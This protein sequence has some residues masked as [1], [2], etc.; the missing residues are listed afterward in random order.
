VDRKREGRI[1][2]RVDSDLEA[3]LRAAAEA[4]GDTLTGI[5]LAAG[6][7]RAEEVLERAGR[8]AVSASA[9]ERFV[10]ALDAKPE[11]MPTLSR[12]AAEPGLTPSR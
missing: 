10:T 8:I 6:A 2:L 5:L 7:Q 11:P 4:N 3:R 12:F 9:F 1:N